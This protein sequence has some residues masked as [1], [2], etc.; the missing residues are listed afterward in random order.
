MTPLSYSFH[1]V[2]SSIAKY[3][4]LLIMVFRERDVWLVSVV[5]SAVLFLAQNLA[6]NAN[7]I[8]I[9]IDI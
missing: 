7:N 4:K 3:V 6:Q 1:V 9:D 8:D 2:P 5:F